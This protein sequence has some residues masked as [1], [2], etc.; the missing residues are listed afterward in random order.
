MIANKPSQHQLSSKIDKRCWLELV[1]SVPLADQ[2]RLHALTAERASSWL[3]AMPSRGPFD[4]TLSPDQV[5]VLLQHRLGV[6]LSRAGDTC[7][8]CNEHRPLDQLG[9]HQLTCSTCGFVVSR[10]NR[11]RDAVFWLLKSAGYNAAKEQ[12]SYH[13]DQ[14]RP[15]DVLALDWSLGKAAAFDVTVVS[16]LTTENL[17]GAGDS[18]VVSK[19]ADAKH[20]ANDEKCV[21]LGWKCVPLAVDTYGQWCAEAHSAFRDIAMRLSVRSKVP[22]AVAL[23]SVY[24]TLAIVLARQNALSILA[25][26]DTLPHLGSRELLLLSRSVNCS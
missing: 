8:L 1:S 13:G 16:P 21:G 19:A 5:Q 6:P 10:H 4:L 24:C 9:H 22:Y 14:R 12:G 15:A 3:Q 2:I 23:S 17:N 18:D 26:R 20:K 7:P 11:V 25:R